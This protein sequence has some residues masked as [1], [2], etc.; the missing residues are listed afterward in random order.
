LD[1]S[2]LSLVVGV[3]LAEALHPAIRL[4]WPNDLW[5]ADRKLGGIL[6]ETASVTAPHAPR[7]AVIG[8]GLNLRGPQATGLATAPASLDELLPGTDTQEVLLRVLKPLV[9]AVQAFEALGFASF[10]S[11]F[12]HRDALRGRAVTL[13]DG[14]QG[15]ACG[16]TAAG[17]LLV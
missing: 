2:G 10:Q 15:T 1:W 6:I 14:T 7:Y 8:V 3:A 17:G 12:D 13:S 5:L 11:R 4:K 16:I 9:G